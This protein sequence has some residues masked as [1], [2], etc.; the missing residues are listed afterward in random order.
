MKAQE[1][2]NEIEAV[3]KPV[4]KN[5]WS[6]FEAFFESKGKLNNC[7]CMAWRM[8]KDELINL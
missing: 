1:R 3:M 5:N 4:D 7:W 2:R 6:D 8:T